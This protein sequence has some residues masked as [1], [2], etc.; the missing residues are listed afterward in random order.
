MISDIFMNACSELN[1]QYSHHSYH[2]KGNMGAF[3]P[4]TKHH[5][6]VSHKNQN[7]LITYDFGSHNLA[8][9]EINMPIKQLVPEM[10]V[11]TV[12]HFF[13]M[14]K[15]DKCP[16][17]IKCQDPTFKADVIHLLKQSGLLKMAEDT[18][19]EPN[20]KCQMKKGE[21]QI[22]TNFYL[23]FEGKASSIKHVVEFHKDLIDLINTKYN[24]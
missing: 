5:L 15:K 12:E 6:D 23:G 8:K 3:M 4:I 20:I 18:S 24:H 7:I 21:I 22:K 17:K 14:F 11:D 2:V 13:R 16:W 1:Y 9:Y 19:F 10:N